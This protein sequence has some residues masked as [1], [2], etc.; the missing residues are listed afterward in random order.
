[1]AIGLTGMATIMRPGME[2]V[3]A[4]MDFARE[5]PNDPE[6]LRRKAEA[7]VRQKAYEKRIAYLDWCVKTGASPM[8]GGENL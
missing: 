3:A 8:R 1:M 4:W 7:A 2:A 5:H 6:V